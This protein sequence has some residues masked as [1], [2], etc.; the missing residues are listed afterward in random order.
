MKMKKILTILFV[1]ISAVYV[2]ISAQDDHGHTHDEPVIESGAPAGIFIIYAES[3]KYEL[4]LKHQRINPSEEGEFV[5]YIADYITNSPLE[6]VDISINVQQDPSITIS[7]EYHEPGVYH[8][9]GK[10]PDAQAYSLA[11]N[12]NSPSKGADLLLLENVE[13]GKDP[14]EVAS[15]AH[16][17][18]DQEHTSGWWKYALVFAGGFAMGYI[19]LR[20][21][22]KTISMILIIISIPSVFQIAEAHGPTG[23]D[24]DKAATAGNNVFILK[25][26]QFLFDIMT[27][28][29]ATGEFQ[30]SVELFGTVV[31]SP[32]GFANISTSQ[33]GRLQSIRVVPGQQV[34][35]GQIVAVVIPSTTQSEQIGVITETGRLRAEIRAAQAELAAAEKELNRLRSIAD[36]AAKKD[37][38]AAEARYNAAKANLD[39]LQ[40]ISSGSVTSSTGSITL[41]SPVSGTVGQFSLASGAEVIAG[42][43][44]FSITNLEKVFVEAQVYDRDADIVKNAA[45]YTVTCTNDD[46]HKTA[47][48]R[49]ISAALEVNPSNQS[50]KVLFEILNP[51]GEFKIGEFVTLQAYQQKSDKTVFVPNSALSEISGMPVIFLKDGPEMYS[52]SYVSLG[53]DNGMHTV[54]LK[55]IENGKRYVTEG[56]YQV[57]MMMLNQ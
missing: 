18:T 6:D 34:T 8:M 37:V 5:L 7:T 39:A 13:I 49:L 24:D 1:C 44:L 42:T 50:Q 36:I 41:K 27:Q 47:Q 21:R 33:S 9:H 3:R 20:R 40:N 29:V 35:A 23:H 17:E 26:T 22:A 45:N 30:P 54:V 51:D 32:G 12:L 31:P 4:T 16:V 2:Q 10:F 53:E 38:Q 19:L 14:P 48:V 57:K 52:V 11:V 56:T 43:T 25:E 28:E 15:S 46:E 55:G